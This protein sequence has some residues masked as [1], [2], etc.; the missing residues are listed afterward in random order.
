MAISNLAPEKL[1]L[2][3]TA[4]QEIGKLRLA[5]WHRPNRLAFRRASVLRLPSPVATSMDATQNVERQG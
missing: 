3:K 2:K 1:I 4:I 5:V